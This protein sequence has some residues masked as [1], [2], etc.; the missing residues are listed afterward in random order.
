MFSG[1]IQ[2]V[3]VIKNIDDLGDGDFLCSIYGAGLDLSGVQK[4]DSIAVNGVCLTV[5]ELAGEVF[6]AEVSK[7]SINCTTF[8]VKKIGDKVNLEA[9]MRLDQGINGHLVTGHIDGVGEVLRVFDDGASRGFELSCPDNLVKYLAVKGSIT[10]D[11]VS[12][13]INTISDVVFGVN[14]ITHT[15]THTTFGD[16]KVGDKVNLEVDLIARYLARLLEKGA[17]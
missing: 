17:K 3:G 1:I 10:I 12:L 4:G 16:I 13:T 11:G 9:A 2:A 6:A 15:L 8:A 5:V 7:V 14:I